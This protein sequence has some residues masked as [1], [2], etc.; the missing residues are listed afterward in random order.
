MFAFTD[1]FAFSNFNEIPNG[2]I[3]IHNM[4]CETLG[5]FHRLFIQ[6]MSRSSFHLDNDG[7]FIT[8]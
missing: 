8:D 4:Y 1:G 7:L 5:S 3:Q 6:R 2:Y